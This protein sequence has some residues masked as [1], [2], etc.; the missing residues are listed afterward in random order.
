MALSSK[1]ITTKY[2]RLPPVLSAWPGRPLFKEDST[3]LWKRDTSKSDS[4]WGKK[5]EG[6][7]PWRLPIHGI[8]WM[9]TRPLRLG[10]IWRRGGAQSNSQIGSIDGEVHGEKMRL[11]FFAIEYTIPPT[12]SPRMSDT[13]QHEF[14]LVIRGLVVS[15]LDA[16]CLRLMCRSG[17]DP[18]V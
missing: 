7:P 9:T 5:G 4:I 14:R 11:S 8:T 15:L 13:H 3:W 2:C 10:S 12:P 17:C 6:T 1:A 16:S 18:E